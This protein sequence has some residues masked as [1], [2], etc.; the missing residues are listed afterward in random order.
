[1]SKPGRGESLMV[2]SPDRV[3]EFGWMRVVAG[4]D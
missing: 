4:S 2:S 3:W 1:V